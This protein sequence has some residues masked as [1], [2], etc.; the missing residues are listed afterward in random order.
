MVRLHGWHT[1]DD[2]RYLNS[3]WSNAPWMN[4]PTLHQLCQQLYF[5]DWSCVWQVYL[6][7]WEE[8]NYGSFSIELLV[9]LCRVG[10][11]SIHME[12]RGQPWVLYLRGH[13]P[14]FE[15]GSLTGTGTSPIRLDWLA[16]KPQRSSCLCLPGAGLP[17]STI[18]PS[19]LLGTV[20]WIWVLVLA[21]QA[22]WQLQH[23]FRSQQSQFFISNLI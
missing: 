21:W 7:H 18:M 22:L 10:S 3:M 12:A 6:N 15:M 14:G 13:L 19:L 20:Y 16:S 23:L 9:L 17:V 8:Q 2:D 5:C 4:K 11:I 1:G